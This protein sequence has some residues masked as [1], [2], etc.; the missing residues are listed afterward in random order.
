MEIEI[1]TFEH[2]K[3]KLEVRVSTETAWLSAGDM[4]ILFGRDRSSIGKQIKNILAEEPENNSLR[5]KFARVDSHGKRRFVDHYNLDVLVSVGKRIRS[6]HTQ[7]FLE[8]Y[9]QIKPDY[10][11][12]NNNLKPNIIRFND[13]NVS[14]DVRIAPNEDT[15]YLTQSQMAFLFETTQQ[16]V[17]LHIKNI[18][19]EGELVF[20][21][22]HKE[23]LLVQTEGQKQVSRMV[24]HYNLDMILSVGYRV[25]SKA[26]IS[27]RKWASSVL[28]EYLLKGYAIDERRTLVTAENYLG[29]IHR[30]DSLDE[31]LA[32]LEKDQNY[33]FKDQ[34]VFEDHVF[35][36]LA[37]IDS[38]IGKA[39][40][41]I[42]LIDPYCDVSALNRLKGKPEGVELK[43]I[44][45]SKAK[46]SETDV[47]SFAHDY[48]HISVTK[49]DRYHDRYLIIDGEYFYHLGASVNYLGK[50]FSQITLT[51]DEDVKNVLRSR[52]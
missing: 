46:L 44:T 11:K 6:K 14:L 51:T 15:V 17:S 1:R 42:V 27:F 29:L 50:R 3:V 21:E 52:I 26:A 30:V 25:K 33:F 24:D 10:E 9:R 4:A 16:N 43:V 2:G 36:A 39:V 38:L 45:S 32:K 41:S 48:G 13:G 22:T 5:A 49:D 28:K 20:E 35:D 7:P 31:R 12:G 18:I 37:L 40:A 8:W 34:I 19:E 47:S 23:F